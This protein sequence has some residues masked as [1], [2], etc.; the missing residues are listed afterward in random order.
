MT[1]RDLLAIPTALLAVSLSACGS[2]G[3]D[4]SA[5]PDSASSEKSAPSP[6]PTPTPS[7]SPK[8]SGAD[9]A[10]LVETLFSSGEKVKKPTSATDFNKQAQLPAG[11]E[12]ATFDASGKSFCVQDTTK[13]ISFDFDAS[14][15]GSFRL[16]EGLCADGTEKARLVENPKDQSKVLVEGDQSIGRPV[17]DVFTKKF[18]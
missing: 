17:A 8:A 5:S 16:L 11:V 13:G 14:D 6:T 2:S 4:T 7:P 1:K 15:K 3:G 18:G 10:D 12:M 9:Y